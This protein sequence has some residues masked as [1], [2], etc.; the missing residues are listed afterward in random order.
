MTFFQPTLDS[1]LSKLAGHM[2]QRSGS[3]S[4]RYNGKGNWLEEEQH[5]SDFK[6]TAKLYFFNNEDE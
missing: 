4:S 2:Y 3:T 5:Y 1:M 6:S